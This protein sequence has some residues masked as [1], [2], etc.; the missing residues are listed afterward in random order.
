MGSGSNNG[1]TFYTGEVLN[2]DVRV[3]WRH[4][5]HVHPIEHH[6]HH[7]VAQNLPSQYFLKITVK[8]V[9]SIYQYLPE[10]LCDV[11]PAQRVL[12]RQ[13]ELNDFIEVKMWNE[14]SIEQTM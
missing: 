8:T 10:L 2:I 13:I 3:W 4:P 5:S 12:K 6:R 1:V 9:D 11:V 7:V 14:E